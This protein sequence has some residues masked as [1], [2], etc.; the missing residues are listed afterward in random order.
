VAWVRGALR[1]DTMEEIVIKAEK[2]DVLGKQV[3]A[4]RRAGKLP[5][6]IYGPHIAS[7]AIVVDF[8]EVNR[9]LSGLTSS[10]L[11]MIDLDGE[12][13][14]TLI[15][16]KQKDPVRGTILHIDFR[17][18][19]LTEKLKANVIIELVGDAPAVKELNGVVVTGQEYLEVECL[20]KYLPERIFVDISSLTK[21]GDSIHVGDVKAPENVA[22]LTNPSDMIILVTAP[23]VEEVVEVAEE[24]AGEEPE[25]I[26]KG[27]KE[28]EEEF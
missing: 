20:P 9:S 17:A 13:H 11:I 16:E 10:H 28:E 21:I 4:L 14:T 1:K 22:I 6:V 15:K 25:I 27:K 26:E 8:R 18:V 23:A 12:K 24:V 7:Q 2:R 19:S 3:R 5:A